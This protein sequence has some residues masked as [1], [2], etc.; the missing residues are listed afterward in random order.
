ML[1]LLGYV[2]PKHVVEHV[3]DIKWSGKQDIPLFADA[4][5]RG[6][7]VF[8]TNNIGQFDVPEECDVIKKSRIHHVAYT[9]RRSGME[10]LALAT[11]AVVAAM[12]AVMNALEGTHG[13]RIVRIAAL[14]PD[15]RFTMADPAKNPPSKYWR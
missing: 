9:Q 11:G 14:Q 12:P 4:K 2:L 6:Y 1:K 15:R 5:K 8:V 7:E 10:G 13:Q 3:T